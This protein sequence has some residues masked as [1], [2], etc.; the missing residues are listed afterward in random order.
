MATTQ[1]QV[2]VSQMYEFE[3]EGFEN[4]WSVRFDFGFDG[5]GSYVD[6][7]VYADHSQTKT[8]ASVAG[9]RD[10]MLAIKELLEKV[11]E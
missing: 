1:E 10:M 5:N 9:A 8:V 3:N 7:T 2:A 4:E 6:A 11:K